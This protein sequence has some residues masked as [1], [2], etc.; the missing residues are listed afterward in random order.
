VEITDKNPKIL[1]G[2]NMQLH[3][4]PRSKLTSKH[5]NASRSMNSDDV[6]LV[7]LLWWLCMEET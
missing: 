4:N 6:F 7:V 5:K 1:K 2:K 3:R